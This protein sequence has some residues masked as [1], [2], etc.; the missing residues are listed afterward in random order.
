MPARDCSVT[1]FHGLP[2]SG[3]RSI[4]RSCSA[5]S[6]CA[7]CSISSTYDLATEAAG[8]HSFG[9]HHDSLAAHMAGLQQGRKRLLQC[10]FIGS[11]II[12]AAFSITQRRQ[13]IERHAIGVPAAGQ[14]ADTT[15]CWHCQMAAVQQAC[16][17][18]ASLRLRSPP[19]QHYGC[20]KVSGAAAAT[21]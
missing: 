7:K 15:H 19:H 4:R 20:S 14:A 8:A 3:R 2:C 9:P 12:T 1:S 11:I 10:G 18:P 16:L 13:A 6:C 5:A 21:V 17:R